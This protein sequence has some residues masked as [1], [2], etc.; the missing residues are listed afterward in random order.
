MPHS[1]K[2][3]LIRLIHILDLNILLHLAKQNNMLSI[4]DTY[5]CS[6]ILNT[7]STLIQSIVVK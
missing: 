2:E 7:N 3:L 5:I 4:L 6:I 1:T